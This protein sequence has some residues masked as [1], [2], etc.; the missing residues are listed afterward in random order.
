[1][2]KKFRDPGERRAVK[3]GADAI[4]AISDA[5]MAAIEEAHDE[6][7]LGTIAREAAGPV[8]KA[9][10]E[11][12]FRAAF[13]DPQVKASFRSILHEAIAERARAVVADYAEEVDAAVRTAIVDGWKEAV[14]KS[15]RIALDRALEEVAQ[16]FRVNTKEA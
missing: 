14:D 3:R 6:G 7:G 1:M 5:A 8:V 16:R 15:A 9:E 12:F 11:R 2:R 4:C 10:L 13:A